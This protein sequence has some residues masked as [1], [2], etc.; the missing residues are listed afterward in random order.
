[1]RLV[2]WCWYWVSTNEDITWE[3]VNNYPHLPWD[4]KGLSYNN[5]DNGKQKWVHQHIQ[6]TIFE[7]LLQNKILS[8]ELVRYIVS[9]V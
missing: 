9:F 1:M 3:V 7:E 6:D 4:L 2:D 8:E 5:M